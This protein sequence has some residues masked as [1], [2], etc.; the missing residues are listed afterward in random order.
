MSCIIGSG[1]L[2]DA[3]QENSRLSIQ[4]PLLLE[5]HD[6][7][8]FLFSLGPLSSSA[9]ISFLRPSMAHIQSLPFEGRPYPAFSNPLQPAF[10]SLHFPG[11]FPLSHL[12]FILL[13]S[14]PHLPQWAWNVL[15]RLLCSQGNPMPLQGPQKWECDLGKVP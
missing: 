12:L 3:Y 5:Q 1:T 8:A 2:Q 10:C 14:L 13:T 4:K 15:F 7:Q 6:F 11:G 9:K